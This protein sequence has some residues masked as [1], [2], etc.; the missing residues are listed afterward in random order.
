MALCT[1]ACPAAHSIFIESRTLSLRSWI[2]A[3][4]APNAILAGSKVSRSR[5][6]LPSTLKTPFPGFVLDPV[7]VPDA[8]ELLAH[9]V[10][11]DDRTLLVVPAI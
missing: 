4:F 9:L 2:L 6:A 5:T 11:L 7:V 1:V 3:T 10:T 8:Q